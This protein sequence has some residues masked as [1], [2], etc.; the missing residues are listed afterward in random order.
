MFNEDHQ[1]I[2]LGLQGLVGS[3]R[4]GSNV[5]NCSKDSQSIGK[6]LVFRLDLQTIAAKR[7]SITLQC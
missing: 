2:L 1:K 4:L 3:L 6:D 5:P 7:P